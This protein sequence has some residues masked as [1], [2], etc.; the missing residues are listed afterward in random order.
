MN[1][2]EDENI[3]YL[4]NISTYSND[5]TNAYAKTKLILR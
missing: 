5:G 2:K 3:N 1:T 4:E